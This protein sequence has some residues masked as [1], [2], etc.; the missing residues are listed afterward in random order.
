[1]TDPVIENE[2]EDCG[3]GENPLCKCVNGKKVFIKIPTNG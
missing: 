3:C 1:M 2:S